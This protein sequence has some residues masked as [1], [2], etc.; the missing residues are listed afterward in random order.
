MKRI[1][2]LNLF[3]VISFASFGQSASSG[4]SNTGKCGDN[5]KWTYVSGT[6]TLSLVKPDVWSSMYNYDKTNIAPWNKKKLDIK[7]VVIKTGVINIGSCAFAGCKHLEEVTLVNSVV[8]IGWGAFADCT[9]LH[10]IVFPQTLSK[11]ETIAF[12]NCSSLNSILIPA[13]VKVGN[14]AFLNCSNVKIIDIHPTV[15]LGNYVFAKEIMFQGKVRHALYDGEIKQ[16]PMNINSL[17]CQ[18]Y[19]ISKNSIVKTKNSASNNNFKYDKVS[20]EVDSI[21]PLSYKTRSNTYALII[22]NENYRFNTD[23]P[24]AIHDALVFRKYCEKALGIPSENIHIC[25]DATKQMIIDDEM[26]W[27]NSIQGR[28]IKRLIVYYAGHGA[29]DIKNSNKA[30]LIPTDVRGTA[31]QR[32]IALDDF[33]AMLGDL[34][35]EQT[36]IFMDACFS[37]INRDNNGINS[38]LRAVE[39]EAEEGKLSTGNIVVF[40]ATQGN[41]T[42]QA[43]VEK[44][45]GLFTYYLLKN[46]QTFKDNVTYGMLFEKVFNDVSKCARQLKLRKS[47]TPSAYASESMTNWQY[48]TF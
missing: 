17:N 11:I 4:F 48:L 3:I 36:S 16:L 22:G 15:I 18:E 35:F 31:P 5:V 42:A 8:E 41:E 13:G 20:A 2:L 23:V 39:V 14:Q 40:S 28:D 24:F 32:G 19:G 10:N 46:L 43:Y 44:G 30:Y 26:D 38:G 12:A 7:R 47:Q 33:Y 6:L 21:I 9:N 27:L 37:G 45:H 25:E 1:F 34:G 29:P